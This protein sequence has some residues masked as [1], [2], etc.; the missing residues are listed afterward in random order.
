MRIR[1][2]RRTFILSLAVLVVGLAVVL[3][4]GFEETFLHQHVIHLSGRVVMKDG[5]PIPPD[6]KITCIQKK[7]PLSLQPVTASINCLEECFIEE[8]DLAVKCKSYT[9]APNEKGEFLLPVFNTEACYLTPIHP[10]YRISTPERIDPTFPIE[11]VVLVLEAGGVVEGKVLSPEGS[12]LRSA[13]VTLWEE[14][15][16]YSIFSSQQ[17][18]MAPY[19]TTTD[20]E[21]CFRIEQAPSDR[22]LSL[23]AALPGFAPVQEKSIRLSERNVFQ[24]DVILQPPAFIEGIVVDAAGIPAA[25]VKVNLF[26]AQSLFDKRERKA[27]EEA[28]TDATGEFRFQ[29]LAAGEYFVRLDEPGFIRSRSRE[30]DIETGRK[31]SRLLMTLERGSCI[32]G[33]VMNEE[34]IPIP[35]A[36]VQASLAEDPSRWAEVLADQL[37]PIEAQT[38]LVGRFTLFGLEQSPYE[39]TATAGQYAPAEGTCQAGMQECTLT[40]VRTGGI[41][42]VVRAKSDGRPV[43][44]YLLLL[45]PNSGRSSSWF[46]PL[47]MRHRKPYRIQEPSGRFVVEDIAP[48]IYDLSILA[49]GLGRLSM[50]RI[51]IEPGSMVQDLEVLLEGTASVV[52]RIFDAETLEPIE[53]ASIARSSGMEGLIQGTLG[54]D[55]IYSDVQGCFRLDGLST[56]A[57]RMI[58][59]HS[60]YL[61]TSLEDLV[62]KEGEVFEGLEILMHRGGVIKGRVMTSDS[63]PEPVRGVHILI[64]NMTG[65]KVKVV[66]TDRSGHYEVHGLSKGPYSVTKLAQRKT[67]GEKGFMGTP[68]E[69]I[70]TQTVRLES[71]GEKECN[72]IVGEIQGG[73]E[74]LSGIIREE[75]QSVQKAVVSLITADP[76]KGTFRPKATTSDEKGMYRFEGVTPGAYTVRV[77]KASTIAYGASSEIIFQVEVQEGA[78][79]THNLDL[80]RGAIAGLVRDGETSLPLKNVRIVLKKQDGGRFEDPLSQAMGYRLAEV[81]TDDQGRFVISNLVSGEYVIRAG[82][83]NM[84]GMDSGGY[85]I[86]YLDAISLKE[87]QRIEDLR[88]DLEMGGNILGRITDPNGSP[89]AGA[90]LHAQSRSAGIMESYSECVTDSTGFFRY[91]GLPAGEYHIIVKHPDHAVK[92]AS[93]VQVEMSRDSRLDLTL[94][95]GSSLWLHTRGKPARS[96]LKEARVEIRD[97]EDRNLFGLTSFLD[98]MEKFMGA[99]ESREK[100]VL[101][102]RYPAGD[103]TLKIGHP[104]FGD[105]SRPLRIPQ[106]KRELVISFDMP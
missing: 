27:E 23:E 102:G 42:G 49:R 48:G 73:G 2:Q 26:K 46:D 61:D 20:K 93:G 71:G 39:I 9:V 36:R 58:V 59:S 101:L 91:R 21:G 12:P 67:L 90:S 79:H 41:Q 10:F 52:G 34:G 82:G 25:E 99:E 84:L 47:A 89:L 105:F 97:E 98:V 53:G 45:E 5:A 76:E 3:Y 100:G 15:S 6:L 60:R 14:Y 30:I 77:V 29:D 62:L 81:Y 33:V 95:E 103:Y 24:L 7:P 94:E 31:H 69:E 37:N 1:I 104:E 64:S 16:P 65:Q 85:A 54:E 80:P 66:T 86:R 75:G 19:S 32:S 56:V 74:A 51:E 22:L 70:I 38:D 88:I 83:V 72:F 68:I 44:Q 8:K 63:L 28:V 55:M 40:L 35:G 13:R 11:E 43:P 78:R 57:P 17:G 4:S 18:W 50:E 87:D 96:F 92:I 106:G